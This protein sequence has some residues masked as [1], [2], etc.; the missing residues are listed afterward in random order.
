MI[1]KEH[2][3]Q[4][5]EEWFALRKGRPTASQ[6]S[7]ILTPT[8]ALSK[9][10]VKYMDE[11]IAE[12]FFPDHVEF[13]GNRHTDRGNELEPE[14]REA[15]VNVTGHSIQE[16]GFCTRDD[17]VVGC[18][19]D[20]L[21]ESPDG[22]YMA[23]LEIKCPAPKTHVGHLR[24]YHE[25]KGLGCSWFPSEHRVQVHGGMAVTELKEWHFFSYCPG[26]QSLHIVVKHDHY[27]DTLSKSLDA[28]LI[29]YGKLREALIPKLQ[30]TDPK[31]SR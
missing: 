29:D 3:V 14:A 26:L 28:F 16:V 11:L 24:E 2:V 22:K 6:F 5:S 27:T 25:A 21:I 8:G 15:F 31:P 4:G 20:G 19:P 30:L 9:T 23:G 10:S 7:K 18:S 1:V 17:G 12:C 13:E